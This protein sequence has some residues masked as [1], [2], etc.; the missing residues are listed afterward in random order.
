[1]ADT[2]NLKTI[3]S[4][5]SVDAQ[6]LSKFLN[7]SKYEMV[8]RRRAPTIH[9]LEF[10]VSTIDEYVNNLSG[11]V[12]KTIE[13]YKLQLNKNLTNL[14]AKAEQDINTSA[15]QVIVTQ[16]AQFAQQMQ[17]AIT[18]ITADK[19]V[20][21]DQIV[22]TSTGRLL[23]D[24]LKD[25]WSI[26]DFYNP[27]LDNGDYTAALRRALE[28]D[29]KVV[30]GAGLEYNIGENY[31]VNRA[32]VTLQ[33]MTLK[34]QAI[35]I[36]S[37]LIKF[38]GSDGAAINVID[39]S[40]FS[41]TVATAAN[42]KRDDYIYVSSNQ[43]WS[44]TVTMGEMTQVESID[45]ANNIIYLRY[46]LIARYDIDNTA[47]V[48]KINLLSGININ[49]VK[50]KGIDDNTLGNNAILL[51]KCLDARIR[52][53]HSMDFD[54]RHIV[55]ERSIGTRVRDST[56]LRTGNNDGLDYGVAVVN[57]CLDTI[58]DGVA[59]TAMRH[60]VTFGGYSGVSKHNT[61]KHCRAFN[62]LDAAYDSHSAAADIEFLFNQSNQS[63]GSETQ[64]DGIVAQCASVKIV[65]NTLNNPRRHG[66][67]FIPE[68]NEDIYIGKI[69]LESALNRVNINTP[70]T[71]T[72]YGFNINTENTT[73]GIDFVS[74]SDDKVGSQDIGYF[75]KASKSD[76]RSVNINNTNT[77]KP[78]S[79]R[80]IHLIA[81]TKTIKNIKINGSDIAVNSNNEIIYMQSING[82]VF[83]TWQ[84]R[85]N[86]LKGGGASTGIRVTN[87]SNG[88]ESGNNTSGCARLLLSDAASL[89]L[90]S[91]TPR[92]GSVQWTGATIAHGTQITVAITVN[93]VAYGDIVNA[94]LGINAQGCQ[95]TGYMSGTNTV[96]VIVANN[97]GVSRTIGACKV[98]AT[99]KRL[100]A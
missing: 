18:S 47:S 98:I 17:D 33:N 60:L 100:I 44:P 32:N 84:V 54:A 62:T 20:V 76:I 78:N 15:T 28:S 97:T 93:N 41:I 26:K 87:A 88:G 70:P 94:A 30:D 95:V 12:S 85:N 51:N 9:T 21:S 72:A 57:A 48:K 83:D 27:S 77:V 8:E 10:Y 61:V 68:I 50:L 37:S 69:G 86:N 25:T 3:F 99:T 19:T 59:G 67:V 24:K 34:A 29:A 40:L 1:M 38:E 14:T 55:I 79:V 81:D 90:R 75:I 52:D 56:M 45:Y 35:V 43:K 31:I 4:E 66:I 92:V 71:A 89:S 5:G 6:A 49:N 74:S 39:S 64:Q 63:G 23:K 13:N 91:E 42:L 36:G 80:G 11:I 73:A 53:T 96:T 65:G 7:G 2:T 58:V 82:G 16:Q 22:T 46:A